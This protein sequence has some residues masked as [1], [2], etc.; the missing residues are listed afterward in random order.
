MFAFFL[1]GRFLEQDPQNSLR[2]EL[3]W[4]PMRLLGET[5]YFRLEPVG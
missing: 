4:G 5:G 3:E 1:I 2:L